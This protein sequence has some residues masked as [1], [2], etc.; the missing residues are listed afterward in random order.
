MMPS[1]CSVSRES[2][3]EFVSVLLF[4]FRLY[5][6]LSRAFRLLNFI[7]DYSSQC[8]AIYNRRKLNRQDVLQV[9][10]KL[11]LRDGPAEH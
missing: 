4:G 1:P 10:G 2:W 9:V 8:L 3:C 5:N 6:T 11:F 7:I